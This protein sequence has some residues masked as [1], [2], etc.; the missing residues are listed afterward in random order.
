MRLSFHIRVFNVLNHSLHFFSILQSSF[1]ISW[2]EHLILFLFICSFS[3]LN[4]SNLICIILLKLLFVLKVYLFPLST[5]T[6]LGLLKPMH[7]QF[8]F[9]APQFIYLIYLSLLTYSIIEYEAFIF[10]NSFLKLFEMLNQAVQFFPQV[11]F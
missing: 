10:P 4:H 6:L 2:L 7:F 11:I 1:Q 8:A 3:F 9:R 5:I